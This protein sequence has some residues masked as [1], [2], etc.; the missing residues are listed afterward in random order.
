MNR[1]FKTPHKNVISDE[2]YD[3]NVISDEEY[4]KYEEMERKI[5][6]LKARQKQDRFHG[7]LIILTFIAII[8]AMCL[9]LDYLATP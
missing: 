2:E 3:E 5:E 9:L 1:Q 6:L 4:A 8:V 7:R